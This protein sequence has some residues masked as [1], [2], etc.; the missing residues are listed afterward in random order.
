LYTADTYRQAGKRYFRLYYN[1]FVVWHLLD[2]C[3]HTHTHTHTHILLTKK[4]SVLWSKAATFFDSYMCMPIHLQLFTLCGLPHETTAI[5]FKLHAQYMYTHAEE[6]P[7]PRI[8]TMC[9]HFNR[10]LKTN[11]LGE[12]VKYFKASFHGLFFFHHIIPIIS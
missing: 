12:N 9:I 10:I 4:F 7:T 8:C 2:V 1:N 11:T 6:A 5:L 3:A